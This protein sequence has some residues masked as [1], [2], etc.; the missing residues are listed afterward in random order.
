VLADLR[1]SALRRI[2]ARRGLVVP[3]LL[4]DV[5]VE[6]QVVDEPPPET[7]L[8]A[9]GEMAEQAEAEAD[10]GADAGATGEAAGGATGDGDA[11]PDGDTVEV[12]S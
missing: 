3:S 7:V 11:A 12:R 4:A 6:D 9:A 2:A 5:R 1:D 10:A 8:A